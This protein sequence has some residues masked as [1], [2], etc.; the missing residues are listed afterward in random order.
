[1]VRRVWRPELL[2]LLPLFD[3]AFRD[4]PAPTQVLAA[5]PSRRLPWRDGLAKK[6]AMGGTI[7][8]GTS[9]ER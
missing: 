7:G 5:F 3:K 4:L 2:A 1:M 9:N 8:N 6:Q